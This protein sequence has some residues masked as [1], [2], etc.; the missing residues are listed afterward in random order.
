LV[1]CHCLRSWVFRLSHAECQPVSEAVGRTR[2][3]LGNRCSQILQNGTG[4]VLNARVDC[5][6]VVQFRIE[7]N[8][9]IQVSL[10]IGPVS[11][12]EIW[13]IRWGLKG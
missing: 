12:P 5:H 8:L 13:A 11:A 6:P 4:D 10:E 3:P 1:T 9:I 7:Q 2:A